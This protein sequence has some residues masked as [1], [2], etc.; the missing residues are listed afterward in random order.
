MTRLVY[1]SGPNVMREAIPASAFSRGDILCFTSASSLSRMP[2]VDGAFAIFGLEIAGVAL[3]D[4]TASVRNRVPYLYADDDTRFW[5]SLQTN[6]STFTAGQHV[7]FFYSTVSGYQVSA[8]ATTQ[9]AT[10]EGNTADLQP[11]S[12]FSRVLVRFIGNAG[13]LATA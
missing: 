12:S 7:G 3:A 6:G 13:N 8:S 10:V 5:A 11:N 1:A 9:R 2:A 4:S